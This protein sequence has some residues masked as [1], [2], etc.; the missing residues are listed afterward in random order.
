V[1]P[2]A[3]AVRKIRERLTAE[4]RS[5]RIASAI[6]VIRK[7]NPIVPGCLLPERGVQGGIQ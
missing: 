5:L 2:S 7:I 1:T 4:M 3:K 6:L